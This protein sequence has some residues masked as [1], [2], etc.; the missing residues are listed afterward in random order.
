MTQLAINPLRNRKVLYHGSEGCRYQDSSCISSVQ[1]YTNCL[2]S[3]FSFIL[4]LL[5]VVLS[6][7]ATCTG[8][9]TERSQHMS[10][11]DTDFEDSNGISLGWTGD[12]ILGL[13]TFIPH[14]HVPLYTVPMCIFFTS[15]CSGPARSRASGR[16]VKEIRCR[17]NRVLCMVTAA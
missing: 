11:E 14:I 5:F 15:S 9:W 17:R 16:V 6:S 8:A 13:S 3:L 2:I 10:I 12:I 7:P 1:C 4:F